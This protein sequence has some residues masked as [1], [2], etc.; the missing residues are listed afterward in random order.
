MAGKVLAVCISSKKGTRKYKILQ[1]EVIKNYGIKGDAHA[2]KWHRQISILDK[3]S[4]LKLK[5]IKAEPGMFGENI[6]SEGINPSSVNIGML[7]KVGKSVILKITQIGKECHEECE[8]KKLTGKCI[9]PLEGIF[10][11]VIEGGIIKPG[12]R[13]EILK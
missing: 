1:A 8:I 9:M 7:L 2:G 4:I 13:I 5:D 6:V 12:D 10:C 3:S 11:K